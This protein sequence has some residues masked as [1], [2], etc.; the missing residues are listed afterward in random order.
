MHGKEHK[1]KIHHGH[2][3]DTNHHH[4]HDHE[5]DYDR[6]RYERDLER[7]N[8]EREEYEKHAHHG[9]KEHKNTLRMISE[10]VCRHRCVNYFKIFLNI[11]AAFISFSFSL[12]S[13]FFL[14]SKNNFSF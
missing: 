6:D 11:L 2:E 3:T 8:F 5:R 10:N 1:T 13:T 4:H 9:K 12:S 7:K 14:K